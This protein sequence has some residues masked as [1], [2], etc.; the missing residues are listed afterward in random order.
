MSEED[1]QVVAVEQVGEA[2]LF[3]TAA[4]LA[5]AS[6]ATSCA[7]TAPVVG[8]RGSQVRARWTRRVK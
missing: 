5:K 1:H 6:R 4:K 3:G 8:V 2:V 7:L